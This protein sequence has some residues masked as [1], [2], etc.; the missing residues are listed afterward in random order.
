M[1]ERLRS[2]LIAL[3]GII[4][5]VVGIT[6]LFSIGRTL[7]APPAA[8]VTPEP[9]LTERV[10]VATRDI[11]LGALITRSDI[12]S[13]DVP[14]QYIPRNAV[15]DAESLVGRFTKTALIEG[16]MLLEHQFADPTNINRDLAFIL[17]DNHVLMAFPAADLMSTLGIIERGDIVDFF[18]SYEVSPPSQVTDDGLP[19]SDVLYT[20][21]ALGR[22]VVTAM[23]VDFVDEEEAANFLAEEGEEGDQ[24]ASTQPEFTTRAFLLALDPQDAL[25]LKHLRDTGA[26]FDLVLRSPTSTSVFDLVPVEEN[27]I[28]ELYGLNLAEGTDLD[29]E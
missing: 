20:F 21:D 16:Q 23:V 3:F 13:I 7:L 24:Q 15:R 9:E 14:V 19:A 8:V 12:T 17:S 6:V 18:A 29:V 2:M 22:V 4:F 26:I 1:N 27:F 5:A 28:R 10:L 11:P 25:V